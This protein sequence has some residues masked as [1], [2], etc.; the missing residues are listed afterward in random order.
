MN[1]LKSCI[2]QGGLPLSIVSKLKKVHYLVAKPKGKT[3]A[4]F[5]ETYLS[6]S[7]DPAVL[8]LANNVPDLIC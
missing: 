4:S 2:L 5:A 1:G 8:I 6:F 3:A 7:Y